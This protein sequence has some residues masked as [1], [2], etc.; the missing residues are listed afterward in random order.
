MS[1]L[2]TG[3][4]G[5]IGSHVLDRLAAQGRR[6]VCLDDFNDF[7]SP[8][9][10]RRNIARALD[11]GR[12]KLVEGDIRDLDLC[13]RVFAEHEV[14]RVVHLAAR[15]GVRP[16]LDQPLLYESTNCKGT[17]CLLECARQAGVK[18]F[19][20][21]STSSIYGVSKRVPFREDH[22]AWEPISPYA[23]SKRACELFCY[24][25]HHLF[26][27]PVVS[28]RFFTVYGPRQRPDLAITKFTALMERDRPIPVYGDGASRRDYTFVGDIVD[29]VL[30]ALDS[31]LQYEIIN[32]GN[33]HPVSLSEMIEALERALGRKARIEWL[34]MPAGDVPF[35]HADISKARRLLGYEPEVAFADGLAR[36]IEW[37]RGLRDEER[38]A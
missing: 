10:K 29:G 6:A 13:R 8:A 14:D 28:L 15:A 25:Y 24:T 27:I 17:L 2:V 38:E 16:S 30:A 33:S 26:G 5:F 3:G 12:V 37:E 7:Y 9:A 4:A 19:V 35:T 34:P 18:M 11:S 21:G 31:D 1:I 22:P 23:A 36:Y 20:F 32:L